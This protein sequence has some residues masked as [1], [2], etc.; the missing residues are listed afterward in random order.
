MFIYEEVRDDYNV[1]CSQNLQKRT[2]KLEENQLLQVIYRQHSCRSCIFSSCFI[3]QAVPQQNSGELVEIGTATVKS[4]FQ[5]AVPG[6][7]PFQDNHSYQ[8]AVAPSGKMILRGRVV[9]I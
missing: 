3:R 7:V 4:W 9:P 8:I 5:K 6:A 1:S 2:Q